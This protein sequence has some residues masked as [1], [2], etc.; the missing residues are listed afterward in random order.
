VVPAAVGFY[1]LDRRGKL[2][3]VASDIR[4]PNGVALSPDEKTVYLADTAGEAV[5]A[6]RVRADGSLA[7]RRDFAKLAGFRQTPNGLSSGADGIVVDEAGRVYVAS[8]AGVEIF[9]AAGAALGTIALPR[10]P[11]NLAFGGKSH[12]HLYVVGR[13]SVYR[14]ATLTRGV[15][16]P[17]K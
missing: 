11:Q 3:L 2:H 17:G 7:D 8:N 5:I 16:R 6:Y 13:G 1:W 4:R 12:D 9:S 15:N 10:Q 14:I